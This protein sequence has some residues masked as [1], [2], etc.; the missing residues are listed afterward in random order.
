MTTILTQAEFARQQNYSRSHV[1]RLKQA[2]RLVMVGEGRAAKVMA[3]E[4]VERI[5]NTEGTR[6]DVAA[7]HAQMRATGA[8]RAPGDTQASPTSQIAPQTTIEQA[9]ENKAL[10]ESRRVM[11]AA[12]KEEMERD[13]LAGALLARE[14]V[15]AAFKSIG[16][17]VR[18]EV[19]KL[20]DRLAPIVTPMQV[21]A[22]VHAEI[23]AAVRGMLESVARATQ[24]QIE[25]LKGGE[26]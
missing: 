8:E 7:R 25:A 21:Q 18:A 20:A 3:A 11:A 14:D 10:A 2:G 13:R 22:E 15:D 12:D 24:Q 9:R 19:V 1:T 6:D 5:K 16:A 23:D 26:A 17:L 4:S